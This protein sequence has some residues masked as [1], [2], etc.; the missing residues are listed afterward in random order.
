[1]NKFTRYCFGVI[2]V[3]LCCVSV[4]F[5]QGTTIT[6]LHVNDTHSHL[7]AFGPK[8]PDFSGTLGGI[9]KAAS[10]IGKVKAT[11]QNVLLLHAGDVFHGELFYNKYFGVPEFQIMQQLGF[12]AMAVGN[13]EFEFGPDVLYGSLSTAFPSGGGVPLLSANT[14]LTEYPALKAYIAPSIVVEKGGVKVAIFGMTVPD[15][16]TTFPAPARILP[17]VVL[18][19]AQTVANLKDQ[20][21]DIIICL[22]HLGSL[23]D[24]AVAANVPGIDV[25]VGGHDHYVF[26]QPIS[27]TNAAGKATLI[28]QAGDAYKYVGKLS[29]HFENGVVSMNGYQLIKV[30]AKVPAVAEIQAIVDQ[31]KTGIVEQYGDVYHKVVGH[32]VHDID[33]Q[34]D[35][36]S[37][38]RDTPLGDLITDACR[39]KTGTDIAITAHG[40]MGDKMYAGAVVGADVFRSTSYG[41]DPATGLGFKLVK[42]KLTGM[43][44]ITGLEATLSYLGLSDDFFLEVS[45]MKFR[46]DATRP[47][48]ERVLLQSM[49][50]NGKPIN[51]AG[52]YSV[53]VNEGIAMLFPLVGVTPTEVELTS[54]LEYNVVRDYIHH[55]RVLLYRSDGRIRDMSVAQGRCFASESEESAEEAVLQHTVEAPREFQLLQN[56]PNPFNPSTSISFGVPEAS[57]VTLRVYD[58]LGRE[59]ATLANED[60]AAGTYTKMFNAANLASGVYIYRLTSGSLV[61]MKK[62]VLMK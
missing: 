31:L 19:A 48:G 50:V 27:V 51:P 52:V 33:R 29:L 4:L 59:V 2:A 60:L 3:C 56:Y 20:G 44:I 32:A 26:E 40:F 54:E 15:D 16:P 55:L 57:S 39:K 5:A 13:H 21:A 43:D 45:G 10:V 1:M 12:D 47:V 14:D 38:L 34:Y 30:D 7:D 49:R 18:I 28:L 37:Q 6:L 36:Q 9:A 46:Y 42:M 35:P 62:M 8:K 41:F 53:T 22:S 25:I 11:E 23:Y 58:M 17:D 24:K 61:Q